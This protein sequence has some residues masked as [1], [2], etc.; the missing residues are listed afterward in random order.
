MIMVT[1]GIKT[2][3]QR[4]T[5]TTSHALPVGATITIDGCG[6]GFKGQTV[7]GGRN[8]ATGR[9]CKVKTLT[10]YKVTDVC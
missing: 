1:L 2:K 6:I 8:V 9:K 5:V 4:T 3:K 7:V 10:L